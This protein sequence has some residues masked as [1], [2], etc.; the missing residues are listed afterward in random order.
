MSAGLATLYQLSG[1]IDTILSQGAGKNG[2]TIAV[3]FQVWMRCSILK[4]ISW[5]FFAKLPIWEKMWNFQGTSVM[6]PLFPLL[7]VIVPFCMIY[8]NAETTVYDEN[9]T[10]FCLCFGAV[11]M[12]SIFFLVRIVS[13]PTV[14]IDFISIPNILSFYLV[15]DVKNEIQLLTKSLEQS[16]LLIQ[17]VA[18]PNCK[19]LPDFRKFGWLF[20][21]VMDLE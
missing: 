3:F 18:F 7:M 6:F 15:T 19:F 21:G 9:I 1:H 17:L 10:L 2:S 8:S 5:F 4:P 11:G 14:S 16:K 13:S 12:I 20:V